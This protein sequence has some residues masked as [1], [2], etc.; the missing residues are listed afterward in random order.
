MAF[1]FTT[2]F[3]S[4]VVNML[5]LKNNGFKSFILQL[6]KTVFTHI[7]KQPLVFVGRLVFIF[8]E[9]Y[10]TEILMTQHSTG[11]ER[12][13]EITY[14]TLLTGI[15]M[16]LFRFTFQAALYHTWRERN[17]RKHGDDPRPA[18]LIINKNISNPTIFTSIII[19]R[20]EIAPTYF[21]FF[22][23]N[24]DFYFFFYL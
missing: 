13:M 23:Y 5:G 24:R 15:K 4:I 14:S 10:T 7:C 8:I 6:F 17:C 21:Y 1:I 18:D 16:F 9:P 20:G 2:I 12:N 19:F 11:W 3:F 22:F